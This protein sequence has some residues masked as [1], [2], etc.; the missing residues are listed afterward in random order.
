VCVYYYPSPPHSRFT[1]QDQER[2]IWGITRPKPSLPR[3]AAVDRGARQSQ[4]R[5]L[6]GKDGRACID[7]A[8]AVTAWVTARELEN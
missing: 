7:F 8:F 6:G 2:D 5:V 1:P 4:A 3:L